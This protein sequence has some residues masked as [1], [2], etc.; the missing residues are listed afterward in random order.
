MR[1]IYPRKKLHFE[2]FMCV[3]C[4][5][6]GPQLLELLMRKIPFFKEYFL[7]TNT[8]NSVQCS[9]SFKHCFQ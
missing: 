4:S 2:D 1:G 3:T 6:M 7:S 9:T 5:N 8:R